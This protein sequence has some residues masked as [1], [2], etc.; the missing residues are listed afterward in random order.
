MTSAPRPVAPDA[1]LTEAAGEP[2]AGAIPAFVNPV[3][4]G[5]DSARDA[6]ARDSRFAIHEVTPERL[7]EAARHA[8][9]GG[10]RRLLVAGGDGT[11]ATVAG[12]L[13]ETEV[14]LAVLP[15]GTLNH[16]A[17]HLGIPTEPA[18]A[19]E[20]AVTGAARLVDAAFVNERLFVNTSSVGAYVAFVRARE[21]LEPILGYWLS[22][23]VAGVRTLFYLPRYRISLE[24]EGTVRHYRTTLVFVGVGERV[25]SPAKLGQRP[26]AGREGLHVIVVRGSRPA[27]LFALALAAAREGRDGVER[28]PEVDSFVVERCSVAMFGRQVRVATD[29]EV[30]RD[31][32][33]LEYRVAHGALRVVAPPQASGARSEV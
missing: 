18:A 7:A 31:A 12:A 14:E 32:P 11:I 22:S 15:G 13:A 3:A 17:T 28:L 5:A 1:S 10:A 20:V 33:P 6:L 23:L 24:V 9:A 8:A 29:G 25:L 19:L 16:F 21:R 26:A 30:V 2:G 27:R 4:G